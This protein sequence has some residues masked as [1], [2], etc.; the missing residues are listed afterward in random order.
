MLDEVCHELFVDE[1]VKDFGND[2]EEGDGAV[3]LGEGFVL[4]FVQF[5]YL[6]SF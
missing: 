5:Y 1:R 6:G 4:C 2:G 3:V